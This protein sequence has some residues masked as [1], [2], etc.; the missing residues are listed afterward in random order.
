LVQHSNFTKKGPAKKWWKRGKEN[1]KSPR[2]PIKEKT[3]F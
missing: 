2:K 1:G 3:N